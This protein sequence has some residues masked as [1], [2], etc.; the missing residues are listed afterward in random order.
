MALD[1][2][3]TSDGS[4]WQR[5]FWSFIADSSMCGE[6]EPI[7]PPAGHRLHCFTG[8]KNEFSPKL[9]HKPFFSTVF[10]LHTNCSGKRKT[11]FG[12]SWSDLPMFNFDA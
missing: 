3:I 2:D 4:P 5:P 11:Q 1:Q 9:F 6:A 12:I 10:L 8:I 7:L